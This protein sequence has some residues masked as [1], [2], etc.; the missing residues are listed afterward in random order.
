MN[1][2]RLGGNSSIPLMK[3]FWENEAEKERIEAVNFLTILSYCRL[4]I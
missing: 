3:N 4:L 1:N 2:Q